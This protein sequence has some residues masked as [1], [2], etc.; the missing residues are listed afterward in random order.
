MQLNIGKIREE[1]GSYWAELID[2]PG[3]FASGATP[4]EFKEAVVEAIKT[5]HESKPLHISCPSCG[6][7]DSMRSREGLWVC[8]N[9]GS[10]GIIVLQR[11]NQ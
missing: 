7:D 2:L 3:C 4:N 1:N 5:A 6:I 10:R 11:G 9:C 8:G